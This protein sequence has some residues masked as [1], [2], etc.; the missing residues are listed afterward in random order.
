MCR[1]IRC[2]GKSCK[3]WVFFVYLNK[4]YT[5]TSFLSPFLAFLAF[6]IRNRTTALVL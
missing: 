5:P 4:A 3:F 1:K 2:D 6:Q